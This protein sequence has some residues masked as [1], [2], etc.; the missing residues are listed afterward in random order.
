MYEFLEKFLE[1]FTM[2]IVFI[3]VVSSIFVMLG[4]IV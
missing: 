3:I 1:V 4:I 2:T